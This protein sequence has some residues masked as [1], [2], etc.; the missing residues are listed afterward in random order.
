MRWARL[1]AVAALATG[2]IATAQPMSTSAA[3]PLA[4]VINCSTTLSPFPG[5]GSSTCNGSAPGVA[6]GA[7]AVLTP[8]TSSFNYNEPC[9]PTT[10]TANGS[11]SAGAASGTFTWTRVGLTAIL[12]LH[13]T[14]GTIGAAA[15]LFLPLGTTAGS[16]TPPC[17]PT[18][19]TATV[20]AVG[21]GA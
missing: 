4:A 3:A 11:Y 1:A 12:T 13:P 6:N 21:A 8:F 19:V 16:L 10:G 18:T 2:G 14:G 9:P 15:A 20:V 7:A 17:T 5:S